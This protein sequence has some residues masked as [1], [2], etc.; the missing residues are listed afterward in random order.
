MEK[1]EIK[2]LANL[3]NE[4]KESHKL[5]R[6]HKMA[7]Q[8]IAENLNELFTKYGFKFINEI[9]T[10]GYEY[11]NLNEVID[12]CVLT[13]YYGNYLELYRNFDGISKIVY[14]LMK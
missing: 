5:N 2:K 10:K 3:L 12:C 6:E 13:A 11:S 7:L 4:Y 14:G 8:L 9:G 1:F